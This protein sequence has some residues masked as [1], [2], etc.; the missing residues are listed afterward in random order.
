MFQAVELRT[1]L[2]K[3]EKGNVN[4]ASGYAK[5]AIEKG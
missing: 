4:V 3:V 2:S 5:T 1:L